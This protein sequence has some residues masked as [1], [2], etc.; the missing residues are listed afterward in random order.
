MYRDAL[1]NFT[2]TESDII[3]S[4]Q[5]FAMYD[6]RTGWLGTLDIMQPGEGYML[7]AN[8]T[9][10]MSLTYPNNTVLKN[11]LMTFETIPPSDWKND[12][13]RYA[14]NLSVVGKIDNSAFPEVVIN[15]QMV[16]GAFINGECHGFVSPITDTGIGFDPFF[17]NVSSNE[18]G[19]QITF[20][21]YDGLTGN[22]YNIE[23]NE[24]F[25]PDAVFGDTHQPLVLTLN[26]L[27][28]GIGGFD[29]N[30]FIRIYPNPFEGMVNVEFSKTANNVTIDVLNETGSLVKRIYDDYA[31]ETLNK[32]IWDGTNGRNSNVSSGIY[33]IRFV[34]GDTTKTMKISKLR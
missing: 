18:S 27:T 1:R 15:S 26:G 32:V 30:N 10:T 21:L 23:E 33:Y 34:S 4:Q 8:G 25:I 3:K 28:T 6:S 5:S 13:T 19:Q 16:L 20:M 2:A 12:L 29:N 22:T 11:S 14:V 7:R 17:L 31:K 9:G 24:T